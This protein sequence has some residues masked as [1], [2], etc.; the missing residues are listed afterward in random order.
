MKTMGLERLVLVRPKHY[1]SAD[2]SARAAGADSVLASARVVGDLL[3]AVADCRLV[4]GA[5]ARH[6]AVPMQSVDPRQCATLVWER[7][8]TGP[9][10]IVLGPEQSG[11]S[12][13]AL[14][15]CHWLVHIPT[16]P[17]FGSL[18][19][20]MAVQ[21]L[22]YELRMQ[23][24]ERQPRVTADPL[25]V[26]ASAEAFEGFQGHLEDILTRSGFLHPAHPQQMRL[27]LRRLFQRAA[28][29]DNEVNI[30]RGV[31]TALDPDRARPQR[32][33]WPRRR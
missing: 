17:S 9:V 5:S 7:L 31:L 2:A 32:K 26:P 13:N 1:P 29:D 11:L 12:N 27:K 28:L 6:R 4:I 19:L 20:A 15:L 14:A 33:P 18:N 3:T 23:E 24:L 16:V 21:V 8:A 22:C 25:R 30:L 10:A